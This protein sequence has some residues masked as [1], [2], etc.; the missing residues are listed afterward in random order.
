MR[1]NILIAGLTGSALLAAGLLL[2]QAPAPPSPDSVKPEDL[3][4]NIREQ[5]N[6]VL[7]PVSVVDAQHNFVNG[8]TVLDFQLYDNGVLQKITEDVSTRPISLVVVVQ[9]TSTARQILPTVQK[10]ASLYGPL[11]AGENG[12]V[13]VIAFD[14]RIQT[15]TGFTSNQDEIKAAFDK[16]KPGSTNNHLND[17]LME[18]VR[19][20]KNRGKERKKIVLAISENRDQGSA[21]HVRDVLT[22]QEFA[23]VV[24]YTVTMSHW[25]N[26]LTAKAEPN[27]PNPIPPEARTPL[28]MGTIRTGTTDAQMN[29]GNYAPAIREIYTAIKGIFIPNALEVYT[30]ETGGREHNFV[31]LGGLEEAVGQIGR[32]IHSQ[33]MLTYLPSNRNEGGYHEITVRVVRPGVEVR[34]RGGYWIAPNGPSPAPAKKK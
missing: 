14:H 20:L 12:E 6:F 19:M 17:A 30:K 4:V 11:V 3:N 10:S 7:A 24:V 18:G 23:D 13:A 29:M 1:R 5:F 8:L 25:I 9:A 34:T 15:L 21:V 32:E 33:Y 2:A 16:I 22:E 31:S 27:R 26:Q 28:P